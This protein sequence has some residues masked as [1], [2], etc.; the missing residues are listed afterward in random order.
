MNTYDFD[1]IHQRRG[2]D[3]SK[4]DETKPDVL[5]LWVADMD[6]TSPPE[7][8]SALEEAVR[9]GIF[10]YPF[11]G[12]QSQEIVANWVASRHGWQIDPASV[13]LLPGV[14][15]GFNIAARSVCQSGE[16]VLVQTPGYGPFLQVARNL[17]LSQQEMQL[18]PDQT[19]QYRVDLDIFEEAITP[20]TRIF[21]LCNPQNPTGR[22]FTQLELEGMAEI[23]LRHG[24]TIC[25]DEIHSDLIYSGHTHVP[26]ASLDP[27]ISKQTITL[28]APSKTFNIAGLKASAAIIEDEELCKQFKASRKG[29]VGFVNSLG[30]VALQAAYQH[31]TPWLEALL[32][33]LEENRNLTVQFVRER[34]PG[35]DIAE[36]EST[37][38]AWLNC[39]A[40]GLNPTGENKFNPFFE[41][42]ARVALNEG[43]GYGAGG[44]GFVR[45]NFGC[46][47]SILL[48]ALQRMESALQQRN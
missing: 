47:R 16:G 43:T 31:G 19:G 32:A 18:I 12:S 48:D 23:C 36:P 28:I 37:Y 2:T 11:Y 21:M 34:L 44:E 14:V 13:I 17:G 24:V 3:C 29:L 20:E 4:W 42:H 40:L 41:E 35:V 10:G 8:T 26:I 30:M 5:P 15:T 45:L 46:P 27:S 6:F 9:H 39:R 22:V 33:Y 7:V 38:L 1:T 25:S